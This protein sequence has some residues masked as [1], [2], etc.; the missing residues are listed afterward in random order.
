[1]VYLSYL[2]DTVESEMNYMADV[3]PLRGIRYANE[4]IGDLAQVVTPPYDVITSEAQAT[5]I[6]TISSAWNLDRSQLKIP[7]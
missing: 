6:P 2:L 5:A 7:L 4:T 3:Q 1:M